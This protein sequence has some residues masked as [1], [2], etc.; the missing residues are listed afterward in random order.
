MLNFESDYT[1]GAHPLI[2]N[3]LTQTNFEHVTSY[4]D[5][6][7]SQ[8]AKEKILKT[9]K[10]SEGQV[11]FLAGGTQTNQIV[12]DTMLKPYEG[13]ISVDTGHIAVHEAGAIEY[14]GHKVIT[15]KNKNGL[16]DAKDLQNYLTNFYNDSTYTHMTIPGMVYITYPSEYG[17]L[18]TKS[19]LEDIYSVCKNYDIPLFIDGAR[20]GYGLTSVKSDITLEDLGKLCDVFYI[21]GTKCGALIGEAVVFTKNNMP[22]YFTTQVKRHG[23]MLAKG[24]VIGI[25]F[26]VLFE[27]ELYLKITHGANTLALQLKQA[28]I[29]K[30]YR[31]FI[32]SYTNQ[33]F[34]IIPN[35]KLERLKKEV[36]F[37][38]WEPYDEKHTVVRFVTSWATKKEDVDALIRLL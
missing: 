4:G 25:Q 33:Q 21:G 34:F 35:D 20:L 8:Q 19:E 23:A 12:I 18:Y 7:Y 31:L 2:L 30:G 37:T 16:L 9:C 38:V 14:T 26:D 32:D 10:I 1:Q 5:D 3:K 15:L 11:Y 28:C 27:D 29:E 36:K 17:T 24:R 22:K 6:I 13:V